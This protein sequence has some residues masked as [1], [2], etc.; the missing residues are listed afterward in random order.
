MCM[1]MCYD[2]VFPTLSVVFIKSL[3]SFISNN[4]NQKLKDVSTTWQVR[5]NKSFTF[6]FYFT[7]PFWPLGVGT[8][9]LSRYFTKMF[10]YVSNYSF[11]CCRTGDIS[12][13]IDKGSQWL[14]MKVP[15]DRPRVYRTPQ[16]GHLWCWDTEQLSLDW[17]HTYTHIVDRIYFRHTLLR[18]TI[19]LAFVPE[20]RFKRTN[21]AIHGQTTL[22]HCVGTSSMIM[23]SCLTT[24][25]YWIQLLCCF[26]TTCTLLIR[27]QGW[28]L[29]F[30]V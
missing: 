24:K 12:W 28:A 1:F 4:A 13:L 23:L 19:K 14:H 21:R 15:K 22:N 7:Q 10:P 20:R 9:P 30:F 16:H 26:K 18:M 8:N 17:T 5:R 25:Q 2:C 3:M 29:D 6:F 27:S 11:L